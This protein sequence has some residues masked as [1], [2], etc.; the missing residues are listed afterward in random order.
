MSVANTLQFRRFEAKAWFCSCGMRRSRHARRDRV[1]F[2]LKPHFIP[3]PL[4]G[5]SR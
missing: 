5:K 3:N 1:H 4:Y 2:P